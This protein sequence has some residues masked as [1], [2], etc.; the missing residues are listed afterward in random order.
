MIELLKVEKRYGD[1][2]IFQDFSFRFEAGKI[3]ALIGR[4]GSGKTTLLNMMA[5]L[6]PWNGGDIIYKG[7]AL[8]EY[9]EQAFFRHEL[10]Y[11]FQNLG[12][13]ENESVAANLD[14]GFVGRRM[15]VEEKKQAF[16]EVLEKVGLSYLPLDRKIYTLSG[17]EAQ[18]VSVGKLMLKKP[19]LLLADEPTASLD[20]ATA[21]EVLQLVF[22]LRDPKRLIIIATHNPNIWNRCDE[23]ISLT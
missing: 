9:K 16:H 23:V 7:K 21:D 4:S 6:E 8:T 5:K 10:G 14:L 3:Y 18:R 22:Q 15:S 2:L 19:S 1:H 11:L 17:G 20:P 12:L 13:I